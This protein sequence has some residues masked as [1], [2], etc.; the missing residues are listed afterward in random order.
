MLVNK[1]QLA[2]LL[3]VSER[4]LSDWA[5]ETPPP[6]VAQAPAKRGQAARYDSAAV[7]AWIRAR[8]RRLATKAA[9]ARSAREQLDR[10]RAA[11]IAQRMR[12]A[13]GELIPV[14]KIAPALEREALAARATL[15]Q[16]QSRLAP[17]I[18]AAVLGGASVEDV[19][20]MMD[21]DIR[22]ALTLLSKYD[23]THADDPTAEERELDEL[24]TETEGD[25]NA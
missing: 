5:A 3:G 15:L 9:P 20:A 13:R 16:M 19:A 25:C 1:R 11:E 22:A 14:E 7:V 6:P 10:L 2:D 12:K 4:T 21:D 23:D 17:V 18:H 24:L 8:E